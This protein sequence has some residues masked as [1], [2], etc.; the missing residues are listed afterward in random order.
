[1]DLAGGVDSL[2]LQLPEDAKENDS[3][4]FISRSDQDE[5]KAVLEQDFRPQQ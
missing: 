5:A 2:E 1:M 3:E 4:R